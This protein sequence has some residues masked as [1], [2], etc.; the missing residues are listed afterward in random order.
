MNQV[1]DPVLS[2]I[3]DTLLNIDP[4]IFCQKYLTLDGKPFRLDKN[5]Y[6]P[7]SDIYRYIAIKALEPDG[8]PVVILKGRQVGGTTMAAALEMYFLGSGLFGNG[9][10]P[11]I[12]ILHAFPDGPKALSY[13]KTQLNAMINSSILVDNGKEKIPYM[14]NLIDSSSPTSDSLQYKQF[15]GGNH[16]WI[17]SLGLQGDRVRGK[18]VDA[19]FFDECFPYNQKIETIDGKIS[20]GEIYNKFIKNEQLPLVKTFNEETEEF[21]Y[22]KIINAWKKDKRELVE[23]YYEN[24]RTK[25]TSNH[26]FLSD[27]GWLRADELK[28]GT[29]IK[30][31]QSSN[32]SY[33]FTVVDKII[34]LEKKETVYDIE[35]EDN[36]NFIAIS[37]GRTKNLGGLIAHNCQDVPSVAL[38]TSSKILTKAQYGKVGQGV[39]VYFGTPKQRGSAFWDIWNRSSQQIYHLGCEKCKK[40][41]PLYTPNSNDWEKVWLYGKI[42]KCT[43]C[44]YEQNKIEAAERGKWVALQNPNDCDFIG[45]HINQ[46]YIPD[47][48]REKIEQEKPGKSAINTERTYQNEVLGEFYQGE[49]SIINQDEIRE[50]CGDPERKFRASIDNQEDKI[51]FLGIDIGLKSAVEQLVDSNKVKSQGQSYSVA[52]LLTLSGMNRLSI[53][54]AVMFK[55]NDLESKK[56]LIEKLMRTYNVNL[57]VCDIGYAN[58]FNQIMQ[59]QYGNKWL[60][61]LS[62]GKVG[63]HIKYSEDLFPRQV[64]FERDFWIAELYDQMKKGNVRFPLGDYDKIS[65]MIDQ[66]CNLEIKPS[67]ARNGEVN[68]R[69]VKSGNT[70]GFFALLNAYLAYKFYITEGFSVNNPLLY[71]NDKKNN[72]IPVAGGI[73]TTWR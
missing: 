65:W 38:G 46:L 28:I 71:K 36:H 41:F 22:K 32:K 44:G 29:L 70:D 18:T 1:I 64:V 14:K 24:S 62:T 45:F 47:F 48:D 17:E 52:V 13:S 39:Q 56:G 60:A 51:S 49:A 33:V 68:A 8:K 34:K 12:R 21:E 20:I 67:V 59:T 4:K 31:S 73:I 11:P 69:Y 35:V 5:G 37:S 58:D 54:Y 23:I 19:V 63:N 55:R 72:K 57:A 16:L 53:D 6:K 9:N 43:H 2:K 50:K 10:N 25:C 3:K 15:V 27:S 42:V 30:T 26:R 40:H 7:F 61:S 66:C